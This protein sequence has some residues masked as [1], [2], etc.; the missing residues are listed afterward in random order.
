MKK[1]MTSTNVESTDNEQMEMKK[2]EGA[3]AAIPSDQE[4]DDH[5]SILMKAE[6]IKAN[7]GL[8]KHL[9]PH[10]QKKLA[11]AKAALGK[12][13]EPKKKFKSLDDVKK[14]ASKM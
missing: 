4:L 7:K 5:H 3:A 2:A 8:M 9:Q 1:D 11:H 13:A 12:A 6:G 10:M 14:H